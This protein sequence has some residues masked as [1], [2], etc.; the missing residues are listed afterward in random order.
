M[1]NNLG[2][3]RDVTLRYVRDQYKSQ[4]DAC[5]IILVPAETHRHADDA[6][7]AKGTGESPIAS[8]YRV[9][10]RGDTYVGPLDATRE[11]AEGEVVVPAL[12]IH[13]FVGSYYSEYIGSMAKYSKICVVPFSYETL[14]VLC[15]KLYSCEP[16]LKVHG[17]A[18]SESREMSSAELAE[19]ICI[20]DY[21]GI[22]IS[23]ADIIAVV[24]RS[25]GLAS[26]K[27][28]ERFAPL[29]AVVR[30]SEAGMRDALRGY[31][32]QVVVEACRA[33]AKGKGVDNRFVARIVK[34]TLSPLCEDGHYPAMRSIL[35]ATGETHCLAL[36]ALWML[37]SE[38][39][40]DH[41]ELYMIISQWDAN[42]RHQ[43]EGAVDMVMRSLFTTEDFVSEEDPIY[44]RYLRYR[45]V[46]DEA[47]I[48]YRTKLGYIIAGRHGLS[49]VEPIATNS[50][51]AKLTL[52]Y[53]TH[54]IY[55]DTRKLI[56]EIVDDSVLSIAMELSRPTVGR[57]RRPLVGDSLEAFGRAV[58]PASESAQVAAPTVMSPANMMTQSPVSAT[59][60]VNTM[61]LT[62]P[63]WAAPAQS[64]WP[65]P[66]I[67]AD[68][69]I[70]VA[71]ST[72]HFG[73]SWRASPCCQQNHRSG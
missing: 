17:R 18:S 26:L 54:D 53:L 24:K 7:D 72:S 51:G 1:G 21:F 13:E 46:L 52:G 30:L 3:F 64:D 66:P 9:V 37:I 63:S 59:A 44:E 73:F 70:M 12:R 10:M 38:P 47:T 29:T 50:I 39:A 55:V 45:A 33:L 36:D 11:P 40:M 58:S 5:E 71:D 62:L 48:D 4:L 65:A 6:H 34:Y 35:E 20:V 69:M 68:P 22:P 57:I 14:K 56:K 31:V 28:A 25:I 15:D 32:N 60:M 42:Q 19:F 23:S 43:A 49:P 8:A 16:M 27:D 41:G 61:P 2:A 67:P